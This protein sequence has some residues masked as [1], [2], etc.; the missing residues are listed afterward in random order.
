[1][2]DAAQDHEAGGADASESQGPAGTEVPDVAAFGVQTTRQLAEAQTGYTWIRDESAKR[3]VD[4]L[5][6]YGCEPS[7]VADELLGAFNP[8]RAVTR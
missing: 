8:H 4:T 2:P 7:I 1:M 3:A 5:T 6:V